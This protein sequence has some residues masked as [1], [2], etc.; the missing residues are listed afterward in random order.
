MKIKD[1]KELLKHYG[2][3]EY[4]DWDIVLWDYNNQRELK[5]LGGTFASSKPDKHICFSVEVEPVDGKTIDQ[6]IK[7]LYKN[8]NNKEDARSNEKTDN[9]DSV[10]GHYRIP[11]DENC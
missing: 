4:D 6:R 1:I 3:E 2:G 9:G 8:L 10:Q 7:E 11:Y 5:W